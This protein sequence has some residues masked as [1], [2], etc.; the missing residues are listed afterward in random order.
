MAIQM[1]SGLVEMHC[2]GHGPSADTE[3]SAPLF[4]HQD[5]KPGNML[6]FGHGSDGDG[7]LRLALTDFGLSVCYNGASEEADLGGGTPFY[8][9]PEQLVG[10]RARRPDR[11]IWAAAIVLAKL[12][13]GE[14]TLAALQEYRGYSSELNRRKVVIADIKQVCIFAQN[15]ARAVE[16]DATGMPG[17][18]LSQTQQA[19]APLLSKCFLVGC[20]LAGM[21]FPGYARPT[22]S[23]CVAALR[24]IWSDLGFQPWHLYLETLPQPQPTALQ[25]HYSPHGLANFYL[26]HMEAGM[27]KL[28]IGQ[29]N[30]LLGKVESQDESVV[31]EH[32]DKLQKQLEAAATNAA[33]HR[34]KADEAAFGVTSKRQVSSAI[35]V[36][37]TVL[38]TSTKALDVCA[39]LSSAL[40]SNHLVRLQMPPTPP[41][42]A[43]KVSPT[44]NATQTSAPAAGPRVRVNGG[45]RFSTCCS[46]QHGVE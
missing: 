20:E 10:R 7:P 8:K 2:G 26:E 40:N 5:L 44:P 28:M 11:D 12:F 35:T 23:E 33:F 21:N 19:L 1:C 9:A 36:A 6:L 14:H 37:A 38:T 17:N 27:L 24:K 18:R 13:A 4:V 31:R 32:I 25:K 34:R 29:C 39:P 43:L 16:Q 42:A 45:E 46:A 22:S 3:G 41:I 30:R 15:I